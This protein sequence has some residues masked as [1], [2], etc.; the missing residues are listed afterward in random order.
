MGHFFKLWKME[1][2]YSESYATFF[3]IFLLKF[4]YAQVVNCAEKI[5]LLFVIKL[6]ALLL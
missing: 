5:L 1:R 2:A 6:I 3:N 4:K